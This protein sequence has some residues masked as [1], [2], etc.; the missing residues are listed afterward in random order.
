[1]QSIAGVFT[2][3][4]DAERAL[5]RLRA[6]IPEDRIS[7][8]YPGASKEEIDSVPTTKDMPPVG[9]EM[10]ATLGGALGIGI[11]ATLFL[12]AVGVV[13]AIGVLGSALLGVAGAVAGGSAG[14]AADESGSEGLPIDELFIYADA[15]R[16]G[17]SVMI[18][19]ADGEGQAEVARRTMEECGAESLDKARESWWL[20]L[21]DAEYSEYQVQGGDFRSDEVLFRRGFEAALDPRMR[22]RTYEEGIDHLRR[23][24]PS[25]HAHAA[26][27]RGFERGQEYDRQW[28]HLV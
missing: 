17:R 4:R 14:K 3:R 9:R 11:G 25:N 27:R 10:G 26:F 6:V 19:L 12:P 13:T 15:L 16:Q 20:G 24:D 21:R 28:T 22:G 18:V 8:L 1:M 5:D 7:A 2:S 23:R